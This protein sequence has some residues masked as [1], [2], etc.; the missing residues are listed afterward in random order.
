MT[1]IFTLFCIVE[2]YLHISLDLY[3]FFAITPSLSTADSLIAMVQGDNKRRQ[4][5]LDQEGFF[6]PRNLD[7]GVILL[8]DREAW[9]KVQLV[10]I[11]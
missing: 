9:L 11:A 1:T 5:L 7:V 2:P 3:A 10:S 8:M 6:S 4:D